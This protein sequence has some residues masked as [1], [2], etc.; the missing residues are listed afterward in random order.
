MRERAADSA[1]AKF[2]AVPT[3]WDDAAVEL[4]PAGACADESEE[5]VF[6]RVCAPT[7]ADFDAHLER[8]HRRRA[9]F[10]SFEG[11]SDW[12][13]GHALP[14]AAALHAVCRHVRRYCH[15]SIYDMRLDSFFR[16]AN[17]TLRE[18][19]S[20]SSSPH[21]RPPPTRGCED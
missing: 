9:L 19:N 11:K 14:M 3:M 6:R 17:S 20:H 8:T 21:R 10:W 4:P 5:A 16:H 15:I 12:G 13:W 18:S 1:M 2:L 7:I